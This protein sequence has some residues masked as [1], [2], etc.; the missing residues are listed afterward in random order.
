V[1]I[2]NPRNYY[3]R[4]TR[5][6]WDDPEDDPLPYEGIFRVSLNDVVV[7]TFVPDLS[8]SGP[9]WTGAGVPTPGTEPATPAQARLLEILTSAYSV[10]PNA[11]LAGRSEQFAWSAGAVP[12]LPSTVFYVA[13]GDF[14]RWAEELD[15]LTADAGGLHSPVRRDDVLDTSVMQFVDRQVLGSPLLDPI[16]AGAV[17]RSD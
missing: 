5:A 17:G 12:A 6:A 2:G 15:A 14:D 3:V 7:V 13:P 9:P 4:V 10:T 8:D 16:S 1:K 11:R